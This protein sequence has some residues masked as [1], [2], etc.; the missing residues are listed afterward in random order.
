MMMKFLTVSAVLLSA[1]IAVSAQQAKKLPYVAGFSQVEVMSVSYRGIQIMHRDG[2]CY[3]K[4]EDLSDADK[5][6]LTEEL[7]LFEQRKVEYQKFLDEQK[8]QQALEAKNAKNERAKQTKIQV[9][10]INAM[11]KENQKAKIFKILVTLEKKFGVEN[12]RNMGL[13]G[14][15]NAIKNHI[16]RNYPLANNRKNL[17]KLIDTKCKETE[18]KLRADAKRKAAAKK[19]KE[20]AAKK[21]KQD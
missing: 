3:L 21:K 18:L 1:A 19:A 15:C 20:E 6:N 10:E 16:N 17:I 8:K 14:R 11:L 4:P 5:K 13:R 9:D 12:N 2:L 7:Q